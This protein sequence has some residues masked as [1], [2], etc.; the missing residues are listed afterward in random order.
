MLRLGSQGES[1][2][3]LQTWL[4]LLPSKLAALVTDGKF[5]QKTQG[6]VLEFQGDN[7]LAKDGVVGPLT[8]GSLTALIDAPGPAI[9]KKT[10]AVRPITAQILGAFPSTNNL[11]TQILPARPCIDIASYRAGAT[12]PDLRFGALMSMTARVGVFAAGKNGVERAVIL[13]LPMSAKPT[14]MLICISHGFGGQ[15]PQTLATVKSLGWENPLSPPLISFSLLKH[16]VNRWGAETMAARKNMGFLYIQRA[17]GKELGPFA[18]DGPF[19]RQV[20][21]ELQ[22]LTDGAFSFDSVET[23]TFSSGIG[24]HNLFV[25]AIRNH[26]NVACCYVIDPNPQAHAANP[27]G[28]ARR[29][30]RSGVT[31]KEPP[32]A[33]V[34]FLPVGRWTNE[35]FHFKKQ[36][37]GEYHYMHNWAMPQYMLYLGIQTSP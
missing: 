11:I 29:E 33:G 14:R 32:M 31:S 4:N 13:M 1:V 7:A 26:L 12:G 34:D 17:A 36:I 22:A 27:P 37:E 20:L 9:P 19:V 8:M 25:N 18:D 30:F 23:M 10:A 6:R 5:G 3:Q 21:E 2:R 28:A 35:P 16:V 24:D 15:G